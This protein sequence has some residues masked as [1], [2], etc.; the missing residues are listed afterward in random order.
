MVLITRPKAAALP[1]KQ[2]LEARGYA[3]IVEPLLTIEQLRP[4]SALPKQVQALALTSAHA[5]PGLSEDA[6]RLPIF[7]VGEATAKAA[8]AAGCLQVI[9]GDGD[10][11]ALAVLIGKRCAPK[12]GA[13]LHV[14]GEIVRDELQQGLSDLGFDV[15]RDV[16][17]RASASNGF[18][19]NLLD[20]W[21]SREVTAVLLFSPRTAGILARLLIDKGLS[22]Y[23][24]RTTAI[25]V[26][27]ATATPCR[28]LDWKAIVLAA[29]PNRDALIRAL[30]GSI[31]IC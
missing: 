16:V 31:R 17:Y 22:R 30:E 15:H 12:D 24:D 20:A 6:K 3:T 23:V 21:R 11:S 28:T 19:K 29:Q 25:C 10:A 1:L 5:V 13:I 14:S 27:E 2:A 26:S 9:A 4:M 8:R 7:T 18:S